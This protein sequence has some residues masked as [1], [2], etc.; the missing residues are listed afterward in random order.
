MDQYELQRQYESGGGRN[1]PYGTLGYNDG[2]TSNIAHDI[3]GA[4]SDAWVGDHKI[5][6]SGNTD[7]NYAFVTAVHENLHMMSAN[8]SDGMTR[9]G[10]IVGN[11]EKSKAMNEA[12]TEY[13]TYLSCGGETSI[14]GL[15]PGAYSGYQKLMQKMPTIEKAIGRDC[16]MDV[17]FNN[18]PEKIRAKIDSILGS[19]AWDDTCSASYDWLYNNSNKAKGRLSG[20]LWR[21]RQ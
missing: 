20:Y 17:Y 18:K 15:Y 21:L 5:Q 12:F 4:T 10:I 6:G 3:K 13:F 7:I 19:G 9:R 16:M 8:D 14:G 1:M 2:K 11:D